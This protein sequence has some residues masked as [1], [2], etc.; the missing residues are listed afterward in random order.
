MVGLDNPLHIAIILIVVLM[1]FG[2]KRLPEM[3]KSLGEGLRGFKDS[4]SGDTPPAA[5]E[6]A[7]PSPRRRARRA[8]A[9]RARGHPGAG[10]RARAAPPPTAPDPCCA[11]LARRRRVEDRDRRGRRLRS[12]RPRTCSAPRHEVTVFE[13]AGY[14]GG[15]TNTIRVDTPNETH[16]VDTGLHRL[17]RPQLPQLRAPA[18]APRRGVPAVADELQ[19]QRRPRRL[20]VQRLLAQRP[21]RQARAPGHA[22]VSPDG[23]RHGPLQPRRPRPA[24]PGA[25]DGDGPSLGHWLE[26]QRF[27]RP[28]IDRLIVPQASAVWSADPRQMWT[29][30][31]R[32]LAEFFDNHGMLVVPGPA[33]LAHGQRRLGPLRRGAAGPLQR[34]AAPGH[35]G[36]RRQPERRQCAG[37]AA[38]GRARALRRG[39]AGHPLRPGAGPARRRHRRRARACSARSP[40]RPTRRCCTPTRRC[41]R[42]AGARGRAGT[43]TCATRRPAGRPSPTT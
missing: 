20:R 34:P 1:V 38:R 18:R 41:C 6:V 29:F 28:F 35:A 3:G 9:R 11:P 8:H 19:R 23:R 31:A 24:G 12:R 17:Q 30:P 27:S 33:P 16:H 5:A 7:P 14:A 22:V 25:S 37:D 36:A 2:A 40:I 15:H 4:V 42:G 43:T 21:V 32:F 10:G 13:A 26:Q 39:R